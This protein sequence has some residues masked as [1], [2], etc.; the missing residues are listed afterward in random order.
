MEGAPDRLVRVGQL[1]HVGY[2]PQQAQMVKK[3][4][5]LVTVQALCS[6]TGLSFHQANDYIRRRLR[7]VA[8]PSMRSIAPTVARLAVSVQVIGGIAE[9]GERGRSAGRPRCFA[10]GSMRPR[11]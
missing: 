1:G 5:G 9:K 11:A 2:I 8:C 10:G 3:V 6:E 7:R 4:D